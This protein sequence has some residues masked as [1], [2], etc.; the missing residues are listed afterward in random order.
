MDFKTNIK[1]G[2]CIEKVTPSLNKL[3]GTDGWKVDTANPQ[4]ILTVSADK[5]LTSDQVIRAVEQSGFTATKL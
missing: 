1:C 4:K 5:G 2:G 3:A